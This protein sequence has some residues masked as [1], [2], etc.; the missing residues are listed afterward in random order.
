MHRVKQQSHIYIYI[1][2]IVALI[3]SLL[4]N[5]VAISSNAYT[6]SYSSDIGVSFTFL[7]TLKIILSSNDCG[8]G[9]GGLCINNLS[10]GTASDSNIL[11]ITVLNNTGNGYTLGASVGDDTISSGRFDTRNLV[12]SNSSI[13]SSFA[14]ID[15]NASI[16]SN[17]GLSDN[18][19]GYAF[20]DE[21]MSNPTWS[22]YSGLPLYSSTIPATLKTSLSPATSAEGDKIKFK[23]AAKSSVSQSSGEYNNV[24]NFTI[25]TQP[26]PVTLSMA[27]ENAGKQKLNGYFKL[28]DMTPDICNATEVLD[29]ASQMQAIDIRDNKVYWITKLQDGHCWM[30]QN[31]DLNLDSTKTYTPD[32][33]DLTA[34]WTPLRSTINAVTNATTA[35]SITG[36]NNDANTPYSVDTGNYYWKN[37]PFYASSIC[38]QTIGGVTYQ[39]CN[40]LVKTNNASW[41]TYF[42]T[43]PYAS[44]GT[45]GHVGNYYNF[46][47]A[48]ASNNTSSYTTSTF[49]NPA[50]NPPNS[51]CPKGWRLP[52]ITNATP[53]YSQAG[54]K[55]EFSRLAYLY[56]NYTGN[57][58]IGSEGIE[59]APLY[60]PR[61][62]YVNSLIL[63]GAGLSGY[64]WSSTVSTSTEAYYL[65]LR[66]DGI[67]PHYLHPNIRMYGHPVRCLAR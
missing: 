8:S 46:S 30:T 16:A 63:Y 60:Y 39:G 62:G 45:H 26:I 43:T 19:W 12:H 40:Y 2:I 48:V 41:A 23:I 35:G 3:S 57:T 38:D 6:L 59:K 13:T 47:A 66:S 50:N 36:W 55:N 7:P 21:T 51:I 42:S 1:Y 4:V 29:E 56:G 49:A 5:V 31:L 9:T 14:S 15:T 17:T 28:Q 27:Y 33:T 53:D 61:S 37:I 58:S 64:G 32:D 54:S 52:T 18:T 24:I 22:S 20:M 10:P 25:T 34:N 11:T 44:N 65:G 67:F